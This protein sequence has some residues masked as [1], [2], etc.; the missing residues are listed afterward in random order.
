MTGLKRELGAADG[1]PS[2][3]IKPVALHWF[4]FICPFCYVSQD[5]DDILIAAGFDV[6]DL[7]FQAHPEIPARGIRVGPRQG[8]MYD[9]LE[10][11]ARDAGLILNW[12]DRL[13]NSRTALAASAWAR[14]RYPGIAGQFN[15]RLFA[16]H[17]A[18]GHDLGDASVVMRYAS[19]LG[20]D[21]GMLENAL[22]DGSAF[23]YVSE[24]EARAHEHDVRGTP[25]WFLRGSV[26]EGV[27]PAE[28]F[29]RRVEKTSGER[30]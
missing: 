13:P 23:Q 3:R 8:P 18:L 21:V 20:V 14:R 15:A 16:A 4:D 7:P 24:A 27:I 17:F 29:R 9:Q 19:E 2:P 25:A 22:A 1:G 11:Q 12:P 5:R 26:I 6:V 28:E 10:R 30:A